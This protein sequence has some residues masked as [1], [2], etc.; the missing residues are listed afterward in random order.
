LRIPEQTDPRRYLHI[1][2]NFSDDDAVI[3]IDLPVN[4]A[5]NQELVADR[6]PAYPKKGT[7]TD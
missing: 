7:L 4:L 1:P 6:R 5:F 3:G 2:P